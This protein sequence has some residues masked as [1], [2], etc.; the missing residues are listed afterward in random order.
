M[1]DTEP[2]G[3]LTSILSLFGINLDSSTRADTSFPYR[4]RDDFLSAAELSFYRVLSTAIGNRA[5]ICPKVNLADIIFVAQSH[6]S[7]S[8]RNRIDRKHVDFLLCDPATMKP[9][10]AIEL[11]DS[12]HARRDRQERDAFVDQVFQAAKLPLVH[13]TAK[14]AYTAASLFALVEPHIAAS[15][16]P[17]LSPAVIPR[18]GPPLCPNCGTPMVERVA[19]KGPNAGKP[20]YGCS[21]YPRCKETA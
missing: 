5:V 12:S 17:V 1:T 11:D 20:F 6:G 7:Q 9:C 13:V 10:C 21:N 14:S 2:K 18:A 16:A 4:R 8:Y 15:A 3:C 19:K